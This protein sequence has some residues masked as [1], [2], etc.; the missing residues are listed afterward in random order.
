MGERIASA[1][2][3]QGVTDA[4]V[5]KLLRAYAVAM[6]PREA[7]PRAL[8]D[9]QAPAFLHPGRTLLIL[10]D[11]VGE[12]D[13]RV[14][15]V[16]ALTESRD[17]LLGVTPKDAL[18]AL[19]AFGGAASEA[20]EWWRTLPSPDWFGAQEVDETTAGFV[21]RLVGIAEPL[22]RVV[23][24]EALDHL[25]HAHLW[26]SSEERGRAVHLAETAL[27]PLASR[28]DPT[29]ARR[30]RWWTQRVGPSLRRD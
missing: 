3:K 28:T 4:D 2:R 14:L 6:G 20:F 1:A 13:P 26:Q 9:P 25:R 29:L 8:P 12:T 17:I 16:A 7:G 21:E 5:A 11:D 22:Q 10:L 27:S 19:Q 30:Y 18:I 15:A 24:A 23:L